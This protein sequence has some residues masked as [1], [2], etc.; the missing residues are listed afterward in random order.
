MS[1]LLVADLHGRTALEPELRALLGG[2]RW[3]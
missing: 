1:V 2:E 3:G